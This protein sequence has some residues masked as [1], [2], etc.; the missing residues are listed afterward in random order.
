MRYTLF[1]VFTFFILALAST[2]PVL[3]S[4]LFLTNGYT[5]VAPVALKAA[6]LFDG[7]TE[8]ILESVTFNHNPLTVWSFIYLLPIPSEPKVELVNYEFF[9]KIDS[10]IQSKFKKET[11]W[12]KVLYLDIDEEKNI[13]PEV[14][15]RDI[16]LLRVEVFSPEKKFSDIEATISGMGYLIPKAAKGAIEKYQNM[17]WY[18]IAAEVNALHIQINATDS[19]SV[20]GAATYPIKISF[21]TDKPIYPL[22][23]TSIL[24]DVDSKAIPLSFQYGVESE[25]VLGEK[26]EAVDSLLANQSHNQFPFL[27][28]EYSNLKIDLFVFSESKSRVPGFRTIYADRFPRH[29]QFV[30]AKGSSYFDEVKNNYFLTKLTTYKPLLQLEDLEIQSASDNRRVNPNISPAEKLSRIAVWVIVIVI[31]SFVFFKRRVIR[32]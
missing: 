8:T 11:L 12:E 18:L 17:G 31:T 30:D 26:V 15:T 23:F 7:K 29:S 19:L 27:P 25:R 10:L 16:D 9:S 24:P 6:I 28:L 2:S 3:A 32:K 14:Y 22:A 13:P 20:N 5:Q 4:G 21:A 1:V